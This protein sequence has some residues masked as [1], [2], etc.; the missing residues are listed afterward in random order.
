MCAS[1]LYAREFSVA[2][3]IDVT[4]RHCRAFLRLFSRN[5]RLYTEMIVTGSIIHGDRDR[6]LGFDQHEQPVV[7]QLGGSDPKDLAFCA[8]LAEQRG[9]REIN[10]NVG[11][12]SDKVKKG[13]FGACL[14]ALPALVAECVDAMVAAV[15]IPVT[16]KTRL[17]I[18]HMDSYEELCHFVRL[19]AEAG[20]QHFVIHAR[21]AW[22]QGLSPKE[23]R[24]VPPLHYDRVYQLQQDFPLLK[25][26]LNGG[27]QSIDEAL[28]HYQYVDGVMMGRQAYHNPW[29]LTE[30]DS[31]LFNEG[32]SGLP[33]TRVEVVHRF[34]PYIEQQL[35]NGVYLRHMTRHMLQLFRGQ[36]GAKSWRRYLSEQGSKKG[37]GIEVI[38][39]AL[40]FVSEES[41]TPMMIPGRQAGI[42][43][44]QDQP[45]LNQDDILQ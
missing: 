14:M 26:S 10:L 27:V 1:R 4:D 38:E 15:S 37:A 23:N 44:L 24:T 42:R 16:I 43:C 5:L 18:D 31:R 39:H 34:L 19:N 36:D 17:G 7:I 20:C 9:Y 22:L 41:A 13:Q 35:S 29:L 6:F 8:A 28:N 30:V 40:D 2:P 32:N 3:M 12:P 11:C 25:F 21:K 45:G 33:K